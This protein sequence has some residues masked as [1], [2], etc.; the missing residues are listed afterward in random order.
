MNGHPKL[1]A[2]DVCL[3]LGLAMDGQVKGEVI[4][5]IGVC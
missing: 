2:N 1:K 5:S 4:D 3:Q